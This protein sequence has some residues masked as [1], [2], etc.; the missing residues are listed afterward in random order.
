MLLVFV[1]SIFGALLFDQI[2]EIRRQL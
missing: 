1:F 2:Q